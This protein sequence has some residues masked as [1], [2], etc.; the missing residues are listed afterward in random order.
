MINDITKRFS[1]K[2]D[3]KSEMKESDNFIN[4]IEKLKIIIIEY[5]KE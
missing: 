1:D 4:N 3:Y 2:I 5:K